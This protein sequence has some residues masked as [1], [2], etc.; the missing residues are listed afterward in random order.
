MLVSLVLA[1]E[2]G[3]RIILAWT[4][5]FLFIGIPFLLAGLPFVVGG[6]LILAMAIAPLVIDWRAAGP[7]RTFL[8][9]VDARGR[10]FRERDGARESFLVPGVPNPDGAVPPTARDWATSLGL[11]IVPV[12][13]GV[14]LGVLAYSIA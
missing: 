12:V 13:L 3:T 4:V 5:L 10:R 2:F 8:G 14:V 1:R 6:V 11:W 9:V 7:Q